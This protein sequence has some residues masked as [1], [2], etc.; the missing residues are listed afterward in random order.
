VRVRLDVGQETEVE[1]QAFDWWADPSSHEGTDLA[2]ILIPTNATAGRVVEPTRFGRISDRAAVLDV[3]AFGFPRF[4]IR[5]SPADADQHGVFRDLEQ[6]SAHAPAAA[7]R[8]QGTLAVYIDDPLPS[9]SQEGGLSPWEGFSG[10]PVFSS[11]RIVAVV[12]E[13]HVSEGTG[14]LTAR[15]IDSV[16]YELS[17]TDFEKLSRLLGLPVRSYEL[18]DIVPVEPAQLVRSAYLAQVR[19]IAPLPLIGRTQELAQWAE[20]CAGTDPYGWWQAGPWAGK[21]ALAS[22]FVLHPP[23]GVEVVSFFIT[24][25][26]L[27]QADSHAFLNAMVE[28]LAA[29]LST[30]IRMPPVSGARSGAWLNLLAAAAAEAAERRCRLIVV[31]DGLDEDEAGAA[32][33]RGRPSIA[34]LLPRRPPAG[35]RFIITSRPDPGLPD[36]LPN[37]HPLRS[38][39]PH[40]LTTS[41]VAENLAMLAKQELR[42]LLAG[43]QIAVDVV[44]YIAASGG[45]L[46][47]ADLSSLAGA[48]PHKLEPI[49]RGVFGRSLYTRASTDPRNPQADP[50]RRIYLF[51]HETL[52]VTAEDQIGSIELARYRE[53]VH[54]WMASYAVAGWPENAPG[55]AIRG[56]PRLLAATSD[57]ERLSALTCDRR[58]HAF[59]LTATGS[60][61]AA[62]TEIRSAQ[63]AI[64]DQDVPDMRT[65][66]E[67]AVY[68]H[69]IW[70]RNKS[71]PIDLP[72]L[73]ARL[74]RFDHAEALASTINDHYQQTVALESVATLLAQNGDY[75][76][77]ERIV[78]TIADAFYLAQ[79]LAWVAIVFAEVGEHGRAVRVA[80]RAEALLRASA[81]PVTELPTFIPLVVALI[82]AGEHD[83]AGR[84]ADQAEDIACT[85]IKANEQVQALGELA[86]ALIQAG[87]RDRAGRIADRAEAIACTITEASGRAQALADLATAL[88]LAGEHDRAGR[89]ADRAEAIACTITEASGRAYALADL[90]TALVLAGEHD[91][92]GRIADRA[93]AIVPA[94]TDPGGTG[95]TALAAVASA[96]AQVG[97]YDRA[98]AIAPSSYYVYEPGRLIDV[99]TAR[100]QAGQY[101]RAEAFARSITNGEPSWALCEIASVLGQLGDYDRAEGVARSITNIDVQARALTALAI[102]LTEAGDPGRAGELARHAEALARTVTDPATQAAGLAKLAPALT[103]I[104]EYDRAEALARRISDLDELD[105]ALS[106]MV[107]TLAQ[108]GDY[109]RAEALARNIPRTFV[110]ERTLVVV[111]TALAKDGE[112]DRA[113]ALART[114]TSGYEGAC[115]LIAVASA[116]AKTDKRGRAQQIAV[117]AEAIARTMTD[118]F[119]KSDR[120]QALIGVAAVLIQVGE[121]DRAEAIV[122]SITDPWY[123][124]QGFT[125]LVTALAEVG[126]TD[127]VGQIAADAEAIA[128]N[129]TDAYYEARALSKLAVALAR[130]F[131]SDRARQIAADAAAIADTITVDIH[132]AIALTQAVAAL[133]IV[134]NGDGARRA[135]DSVEAI[136]FGLPGV[137]PTERLDRLIVTLAEAGDI[138]GALRYTVRALNLDSP[139]I[140]WVETVSHF[141]PQSIGHS[142]DLLVDAYTES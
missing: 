61:Y 92:A 39:K 107:T 41:Q 142:L 106:A 118:R 55:Y 129:F 96:L 37:G 71:I 141:F 25:R 2:V 72:M 13:H 34:S 7:N 99:V 123:Q 100:A 32:P 115:A 133:A 82:R 8:R 57:I 97:Q 10:G 89:I 95:F 76:R 137:Q 119:S 21:S 24:G 28:Q 102:E 114:H 134:G 90:A 17:P 74:G 64:A 69:I 77:A 120:F 45:G 51:A 52:R 135:A 6:V 22:W 116:L 109:N 126:C 31:V 68:R 20:F 1:A 73:W 23:A 110:E 11:G 48:A 127:R 91:R 14:R 66:V 108:A 85:I 67:L 40:L 80:D 98:E 111:I 132:R 124:M 88:V 121:G 63:A 53:A 12:T 16:Y 56:Y 58:R 5:S 4:K 49:L 18:P 139:D 62:L 54:E 101:D 105:R 65:L 75:D 15:R 113:E 138:D 70:I 117:D 26:L 78:G 60:D 43:D 29:L 38:C 33:S 30:K 79:A 9:S 47:R 46:T 86:G 104:G 44:G 125:A 84:I 36:D 19:D 122:G 131:E 140:W 93:E 27:G 87:D 83:R 94:I 59:L 81:D 136:A 3:E 128:R 130:A 112:Y 103:W 42:D 35:V 50:A